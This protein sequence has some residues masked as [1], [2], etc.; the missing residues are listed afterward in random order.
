MNGS[1]DITPLF[2]LVFFTVLGLTVL[3]I[4]INVLLVLDG[5]NTAMARD[6]AKLCAAGWTG[7]TA[8]IFGLL[9]GKAL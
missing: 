2:K 1:G 8:A 9:G 4:G 7:G 6:L 3:S 5:T